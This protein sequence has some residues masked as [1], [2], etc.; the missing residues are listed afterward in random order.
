MDYYYE[1]LNSYSKLKKRTLVLKEEETSSKEKTYTPANPVTKPAINF[2]KEIGAGTKSTGT[3]DHPDDPEKRL[4]VNITTPAKE[5]GKVNVY[6]KFGR[7]DGHI[8]S[9]V[10]KELVLTRSGG[11]TPAKLDAW[12]EGQELGSKEEEETKQRD[13]AAAELEARRQAAMK[14]LQL[15]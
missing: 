11:Q 4:H 8:G 6:L 15:P 12:L 2:L 14:I 3:Y 13:E 7:V 10:G 1:L 5:G 9:I